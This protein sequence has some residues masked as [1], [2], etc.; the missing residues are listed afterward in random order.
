VEI[1]S[2]PRSYSAE[3]IANTLLP[4][5]PVETADGIAD[6]LSDIM[7][8]ETHPFRVLVFGSLYLWLET[9]LI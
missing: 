5:L 4:L 3:A 7:T 1:K 9:S 2:E 8:R 6:A